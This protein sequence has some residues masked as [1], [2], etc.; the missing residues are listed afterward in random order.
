MEY[1]WCD[2]VKLIALTLEIIY[3]HLIGF[4]LSLSLSKTTIAS[5]KSIAKLRFTFSN[6]SS[7]PGRLGSSVMY[8]T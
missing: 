3:Y 1:I 6:S 5:F 4:T 7:L 2:H 8:I